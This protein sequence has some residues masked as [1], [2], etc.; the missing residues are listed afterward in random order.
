[1][2]V[3]WGELFLPIALYSLHPEGTAVTLRAGIEGWILDLYP[4]RSGGMILWL[5]QADGTCRRIVDP[6]RPTFYVGGRETDLLELSRSLQAVN[7]DVEC[8]LTR[9]YERLQ[10][11]EKSEVLKVTVPTASEFQKIVKSLPKLGGYSKYRIYNADLPLSQL[12]LYERDLFPLSHLFVTKRKKHVQYRR[13]D[14]TESVDYQL[15]PL[16]RLSINLRIKSKGPIPSFQDPLEG[17]ELR[18]DAEK[19]LLMEGDETSTILKFAEMVQ[20]LDPDFLLTDGGGDFILPYLANRASL[21]NIYRDIYLGRERNSLRPSSTQGHVYFSY[22]KIYYR[23]PLWRFPGRIHIDYDSFYVSQCGLEGAIEIA[24][25]CRIPLQRATSVTIGTAMT[26]VQLYQAVRDGILIPSRKNEPEEFKN[27]YELLVADRG[28]FYYE[29]KVG[30]HENVFELDFAGLYPMLMLRKN[31]SAETVQCSCCPNSS[32]RVPE[33]NYNICEKR[34]GIV[35]K[36]LKLLLKKR[37]MY[38]QLKRRTKEPELR[39]IYDARQAALK[40]ILVSSFGYLG[41]RNARFGKID[42]HIAVCAYARKTL[43]RTVEIAEACGFE[44]IHGIVDSIWLKHPVGGLEDFEKLRREIAGRI[45]LP[46][47]LE[48]RYRWIIF[49]PSKTHPSAPVLTRY[50]GALEDGSLKVRGI[51]TRRH[52]T[53]PLI[54]QC[55][56]EIIECLARAS[57]KEEL[58]ENIPVA[59]KILRIYLQRVADHEVEL[60][61]LAVTRNLSMEVE[62]YAHDVVQAIAARQLIRAGGKVAAGQ[63]IQYI[64]KDADS[65]NPENRVVPLQLALQ[66]LE[67][68]VEKYRSLLLDAIG[69]ILTPVGYDKS[70][71]ETEMRGEDGNQLSLEQFARFLQESTASK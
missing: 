57:N 61:D 60:K 14:S 15:P 62:E 66:D 54:A 30:V 11:Q 65:R 70:R 2:V 69:Y 32:K 3:A 40:W 5:K 16:R 12:F 31:L 46:F 18:S 39:D 25:I 59:L 10:D 52:D 71:L 50:F 13:E 26:S 1:M 21:N 35:P 29:P 67:F 24:R 34:L 28:G 22:G 51:D 43:L 37:S 42:S 19:I 53:P 6:W 9:R 17:I 4:N 20:R 55:E 45:R 58:M 48:G 63:S 64:F 36:A 23:P 33:L 7:S 47:G 56:R 44:L 8:K 49:L 27:A 68:D 38:K 41:F